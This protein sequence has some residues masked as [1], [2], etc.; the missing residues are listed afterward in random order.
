MG[1]WAFFVSATTK[2]HGC[3]ALGKKGFEEE[4]RVQIIDE[5][6]N[7][8]AYDLA[9]G[10]DENDDRCWINQQRLLMGKPSTK[11]AVN[12]N[13][14]DTRSLSSRCKHHRESNNS[15]HIQPPSPEVEVVSHLR[16]HKSVFQGKKKSPM[17]SPF[18]HSVVDVT[19][20]PTSLY[21]KKLFPPSQDIKMADRV[22][23]RTLSEIV[24]EPD[25]SISR[26]RHR[27]MLD[28]NDLTEKTC[29][30]IADVKPDALSQEVE[31]IFDQ[32][33]SH[34]YSVSPKK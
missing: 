10:I 14:F 26:Q 30:G 11:V 22:K 2:G 19:T 12:G 7:R 34:R 5:G 32:T 17:I 13:I 16:P 21:P 23:K 28:H 24:Y 18:N 3:R 1:F 8:A 25:S 6:L 33:Y 15:L 31:R 9:T 4:D 29:N 20:S 27:F